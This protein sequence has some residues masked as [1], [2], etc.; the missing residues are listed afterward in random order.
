VTDPGG[1]D[2]PIVAG[3][4]LLID[5]IQSPNYVPGVSGWTINKDGTVEF[6]NGVFRGTIVNA[7]IFIYLGA[8]GFGNLK[9]TLAPNPGID[10]FGNEYKAG[11]SFP[12]DDGSNLISTIQQND[13]AGVQTFVI[14]GPGQVPGT[15]TTISLL[16][17]GRI[18]IS[19]QENMD[20]SAS[21]TVD[22]SAGGAGGI[23]LDSPTFVNANF[24]V[25]G[26]DSVFI[27]N[28][29]RIAGGT[30]MQFSAGPVGKYY[31]EVIA[32]N[33]AAVLTGVNTQL[34]TQG[35]IFIRS[36]YPTA[37]NGAGNWT[38]PADGPYTVSWKPTTIPATNG[39]LRVTKNGANWLNAG[40]LGVPMPVNLLPLTLMDDFVAGDILRFFVDQQ[41]GANQN[42]STQV[43]IL[44]HL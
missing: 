27:G 12:P 7:G 1:F 8:P 23:N 16:D 17:T 43:G 18:T 36:D 37:W 13:I 35:A 38:C 31:E 20:I 14:E 29:Y 30:S 41:S 32:L 10:S 11:L 15:L 21:G 19:T 25:A 3:L 24:E 33:Q 22:I 40:G 34:Q 26:G 4:K 6:S 5:A 28:N 2:N 44:R 42:I 39:F 9:V